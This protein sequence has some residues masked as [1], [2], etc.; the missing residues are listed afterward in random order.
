[1]LRRL[2]F[3]LCAPLLLSCE[4]TVDLDL[5][6]GPPQLVVEGHIEPGQP[7][8]VVLTESVGLF[9]RLDAG[10]LAATLVHGAQLSVTSDGVTYLLH[11]AAADTVAPAL[12]RLLAVELGLPLDPGTGQLPVPLTF[13]TTAALRGTPGQTYV[14]SGTA[15]GQALRA[16]TSI[17]RLT[18]FDTLFFRPPTTPGNDSLVALWYRFRDP[19]TLGNS[20]RY[21]TRRTGEPFYPGTPQS[22]LTDEFVN[23]RTIVFPLE[24][25]TDRSQPVDAV[26]AGLFRRGDSIAVRWCTIDAAHYR[27][28]LSVDNAAAFNGSPLAAPTPLHGNVTGALGVWGGYGT[29]THRVKAPE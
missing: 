10:T 12:R 7:P 2:S 25:G 11:E 19:D 6:A 4:Q 3:L 1:M 27:F 14:L 28:W 21:F 5:P 22:V 16:V 9:G 29:S 23:G 18:P 8:V 17:P 13:Y 20:I 26:T 15:R 24:R